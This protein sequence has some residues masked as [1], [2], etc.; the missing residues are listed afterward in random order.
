MDQVERIRDETDSDRDWVVQDTPRISSRA[1]IDQERGPDH[2]RQ[3]V[4][5]REGSRIRVYKDGIQ[6]QHDTHDDKEFVDPA[7]VGLAIDK[8]GHGCARRQFEDAERHQVEAG[9]WRNS[10]HRF[11]ASQAD[12]ADCEEQRRHLLFPP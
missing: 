12:D 6:D 9:L 4:F 7:V 11:A 5:S 3:R 2:S 10:K 8:P 1:A